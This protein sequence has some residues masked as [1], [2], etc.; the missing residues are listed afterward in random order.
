MVDLSSRSHHRGWPRF[1]RW[2]N[3]DRSLELRRR[4][5]QGRA[6]D[7]AA[8]T[9][10]LLAGNDLQLAEAWLAEADESSAGVEPSIREFIAASRAQATGRE[11]RRQRRLIVAAA[12]GVILAVT[13]AVLAQASRS[14]QRGAERETDRRVA[15]ELQTSA[16]SYTGNVTLQALLVRGGRRDLGNPAQRP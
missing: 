6:A 16:A 8:Q 3:D 12:V 2:L 13:F 4:R 15:T 14:A 1:K 11:R 5:W 10:S 7:H 9:G